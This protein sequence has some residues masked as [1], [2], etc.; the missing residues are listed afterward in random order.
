[1]T[2]TVDIEPRP[3]YLYAAVSGEFSVLGAQA[4]YDQAVQAALPLAQTR[5]LIDARYVT[6]QPS[7]EDRYALGLFVATEQR[8]LAAR[9]SVVPRVAILGHRPL[10][11]PER[12]GETV[13]VNRG[14]KVKVSERLEEA[15]VW[16]GLSEGG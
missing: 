16:L 8:L 7:Q 6:G 12:F 14:A 13:A 10:V 11:D 1:M 15:L 9:A 3:H 4:A 2:L 5:I